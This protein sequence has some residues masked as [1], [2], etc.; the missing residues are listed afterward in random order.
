M[1]KSLVSALFVAALAMW[2]GTAALALVHFGGFEGHDF[3]AVSA[4]FATFVIAGLQLAA[5]A[6]S[7]RHLQRVWRELSDLREQIAI[8]S[9][10]QADGQA[11]P[12]DDG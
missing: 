9:A 12:G 4:F 5:M 8:G 10:P 3:Y 6:Y 1:L 11:P 7:R 2:L